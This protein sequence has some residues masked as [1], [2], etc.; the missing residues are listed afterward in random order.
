LPTKYAPYFFIFLV[1]SKYSDLRNHL[2]NGT[3]S[4]FCFSRDPF[5]IVPASGPDAE[6]IFVNRDNHILK[7]EPCTSSNRNIRATTE[8]VQM[9]SLENVYVFSFLNGEVEIYSH[10][11]FDKI[12]SINEHLREREIKSR[13]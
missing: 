10:G 4:L 9:V 12:T 5:E 1:E 3:E 13:P 8:T 2:Y 11:T 7:F 6:L